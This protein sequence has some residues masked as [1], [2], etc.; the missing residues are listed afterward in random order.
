MYNTDKNKH[1]YKNY[2]R[3]TDRLFTFSGIKHNHTKVNKNVVIVVVDLAT[4]VW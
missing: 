4:S 1:V 2:S 3:Q